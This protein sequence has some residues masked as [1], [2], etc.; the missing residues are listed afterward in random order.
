MPQAGSRMNDRVARST[1]IVLAVWLAGVSACNSIGSGAFHVAS[2]ERIPAEMRSLMSERCNAFLSAIREGDDAK[3][4]AIFTTQAWSQIESGPGLDKVRSAIQAAIDGVEAIEEQHYV[5][6]RSTGVFTPTVVVT[7]PEPHTIVL[8]PVPGEAF[9]VLLSFDQKYRQTA[10][11]LLFCQDKSRWKLQTAYVGG[12]LSAGGKRARAWVEEARSLVK[13]GSPIAAALRVT[14]AS[15]CLRPIPTMQFGYEAEVKEL[16][17]SIMERVNREF[18]LP[19]DLYEISGRPRVWDLDVSFEEGRL[20]PL[21]RYVTSTPLD[22][23]SQLKKQASEIANVL[24]GR[25]KGL[26]TGSRI[27]MLIAVGESPSDPS[28][29][30]PSYGIEERCP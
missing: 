23:V 20:V 21:V 5:R 2:D 18:H 4:K 12:T 30:Y 10:V 22:A 11:G 28:R 17:R 3:L 13:A 16:G 8:P 6:S 19:M 24:P 1:A 27:Y 9:L 29:T 15:K 14:A 7:G 25:L 26:C